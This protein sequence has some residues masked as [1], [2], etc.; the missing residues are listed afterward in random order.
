M[1]VS[2]HIYTYIYVYMY[3]CT[4]VYTYMHIGMVPCHAVQ[5]QIQ[6]CVCTR[7][8]IGTYIYMNQPGPLWPRGVRLPAPRLQQ[9]CQTSDRYC[10]DGGK[11]ASGAPR[12]VA[13]PWTMSW[14]PWTFEV[15]GLNLGKTRQ[16]TLCSDNMAVLGHHISKE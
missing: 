13:H 5:S 4:C 15:P 8:C 16:T 14:T 7:V 12:A 9:S 2:I 11:K 6:V 10:S 1:C 3:T